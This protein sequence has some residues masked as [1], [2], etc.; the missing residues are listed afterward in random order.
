MEWRYGFCR[1]FKLK[2]TNVLSAYKEGENCAEKVKAFGQCERQCLCCCV[3]TE[4]GNGSDLSQ[5]YLFHFGLLDLSDAF[6]SL[7]EGKTKRMKEMKLPDCLREFLRIHTWS[8]SRIFFAIWNSSKLMGFVNVCRLGVFKVP[9]S[10]SFYIISFP[11]CSVASYVHAPVSMM[12]L[13]KC[14]GCSVTA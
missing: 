9:V 2:N 1:E 11:A 8:S 12:E 6:F 5:I 13:K 3:K 4:Q 10:Q 7:P 14:F